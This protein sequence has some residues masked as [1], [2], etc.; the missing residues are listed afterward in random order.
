MSARS[1]DA[2]RSR[3]PSVEYVCPYCGAGFA[4]TWFRSGQGPPTC[5]AQV[6][7]RAHAAA[8]PRPAKARRPAECAWCA[9]PIVQP[10][11]GR[12]RRYCP[13]TCKARASE[14]RARADGRFGRWR[15][16][17][18]ERRRRGRALTG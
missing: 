7:R 5:G 4:S 8:R 15:A 2:K 6:C 12:P 1:A 9:G 16:A 13:G 18:A 10:A 11:V 14:Q 3:G 17:S